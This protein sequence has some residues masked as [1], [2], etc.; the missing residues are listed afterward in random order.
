M[1]I[2]SKT[3][4]EFSMARQTIPFLVI[5]DIFDTAVN[6]NYVERSFKYLFEVKTL[7]DDGTYRTFS[8][9]AIPPRPDNLTGLFDPSKII[10]SAI[11]FDNGTHKLATTSAMPFSIVQY[12]VFVSER[13]LNEQGDFITGDRLDLGT[14]Y[15]IDA[16]SNEGIE[17]YL[18]E[19]TG[20]TKN[21]MHHHELLGN[22]LAIKPGEPFTASFL[23]KVAISG[24]VLDFI[25][26][27]YGSFDFGTV[28]DYDGIDPSNLVTLTTTITGAIS[29][30]GLRAAFK[31]N[32]F[33]SISTDGD[34]IT[35]QLLDLKPDTRY[36]FTIYA[37]LLGS[38]FISPD[39]TA[40]YTAL[41]SGDGISTIISQV[42]PQ[43]RRSITQPRE[44]K[45]V[46]E[47]DSNVN[48]SEIILIKVV[49]D[50]GNN[51]IRLNRR[52]VT[53]DSA[54]L[55]EI[56][57]FVNPIDSARIVVNKGLGT[58]ATHVFNSSYLSD[59]IDFNEL[60]M[61]RFDC[62]IGLN[63]TYSFSST[64][65]T[66]NA[67]KQF[68]DANANV[69]KYYRLELF[70]SN[71][72][73][74]VIATTQDIY[75]IGD[76][77]RYNN[78]RLKWLNELGAWNY[79]TFDKVSVASTQI[80]RE[81]YKITGGRIVESDNIGGY[82]YEENDKDRGYKTLT[83]L[84]DDYIVINTDWVKNETGKF[85]RG[86][87]TSPEVYILNPEP[88]IEVPVTNEY[89]LE[90]PV[91]IEDVD[92]EFRNNSIEAKL[93]NATFRIKIA[94]PFNDKTTNAD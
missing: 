62:P 39:P 46:F 27:D 47:T 70:N 71:S 20:T 42:T 37:R 19:T 40:V 34:V 53:F 22:Q 61:A 87:L 33:S 12:R 90:Y 73:D 77:E 57:T 44:I 24:N 85:L 10:Q 67:N 6:F 88:Y 16:G 3:P 79:Y 9:V 49:S 32:A 30:R 21:A 74:D 41:P 7:R 59:V 91:I 52:S 43:I 89:E 72:V 93:V 4:N 78:V 68:L 48:N 64:G 5:S 69:G 54:V 13:Y 58:E 82:D 15:S 84:S 92:F 63:S 65:E 23:T 80:Q 66:Q 56:D 2:A 26:G 18:I 75:Q 29:G 25:H 36:E 8:I 76:C 38:L 50:S 11:Q 51:L 1:L 17:P 60:R 86:I 45:V 94:V 35:F 28:A 83:I 31:T 81:N 14:Y 55:K